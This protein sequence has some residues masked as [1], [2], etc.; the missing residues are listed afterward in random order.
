MTA[1]DIGLLNG[2]E[3]EFESCS[4]SLNAGIDG[5][6]C[7]FT[8]IAGLHL[9]PRKTDKIELALDGF[10]FR[11]IVDEVTTSY[12]G[13]SKK[14]S[15]SVIG[16][17]QNLDQ[18]VT[19]NQTGTAQELMETALDGKGFNAS[20]LGDTEEASFKLPYTGDVR[21]F[22]ETI[23]TAAGGFIAYLDSSGTCYLINRNGGHSLHPHKW[24]PGNRGYQLNNCK[25]PG[26][27]PKTQFRCTGKNAK[28]DG[29]GP[30]SEP[31][32]YKEAG[33]GT[34][35][36]FSYADTWTE[37]SRVDVDGTRVEFIEKGVSGWDTAACYHDPEAHK[38]VF[39]VAPGAGLE[40]KL[41]GIKH[42][43]D[44]TETDE[45][46]AAELAAAFGGTGIHPVNESHPEFRTQ[47]ESQKFAEG[48]KAR[49]GGIKMEATAT[50]W[51]P[52]PI[53][54]PIHEVEVDD[55]DGFAATLPVQSNSGTREAGR[56][57]QSVTVGNGR[58]GGSAPGGASA[59]NAVVS[60]IRRAT[61]PAQA[62]APTTTVPYSPV[63][64][65]LLD[66]PLCLA[67]DPDGNLFISDSSNYRIRRVDAGTGIITTYAGTGTPGHSGDGG[68]AS[69]AAVYGSFLLTDLKVE[70]GYL[71]LCG[72]EDGTSDPS[73]WHTAVRRINLS[74]G[75][76]ELFAGNYTAGD[77]GDGGAATSAKLDYPRGMAFVGGDLYL[78]T[79]SAF[80][81][82]PGNIRKISG[83]T[84]TRILDSDT[85]YNGITVNTDLVGFA[86]GSAGTLRAY[87]TD[88]TGPTDTAT[89]LTAA[90]WPVYDPDGDRYFAAG[91]NGTTYQIFTI[92]PATGD[93]TLF[94]GDGTQ[95]YSGDGGPAVDAQFRFPS[96]VPFGMTIFDGYLYLSDA[97]NHC[98]RRVNLGTGI[99]SL[100]AGTPETSGF[101]GDGGPAM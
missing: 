85:L 71:Y 49:Y 101:D 51:A 99:V 38:V 1:P 12:E 40:V 14:Y 55:G 2:I 53:Y 37:V 21:G 15:V 35:I 57:I 72:L 67:L 84:I 45:A 30:D 39:K 58:E 91:Y 90:I 25:Y 5:S 69:A 62:P 66:Y 100:V 92:D 98:V 95:G 16:P 24:I 65:P 61:T 78:P 31:T 68:P 3:T 88:G 28:P 11:G 9:K 83:G 96:N 80:F 43:S 8:F 74:T 73:L 81:D 22:L 4:F 47:Q 56:W 26:G 46:L 19:I 97:G 79:G 29:G 89:D 13:R 54:L 32:E 82:S 20:V 59:F 6:T 36:E 64:P 87:A 76:I 17:Q 23:Q 33:D 50:V 94:A 86:D 27:L 44:H 60:R 48:M 34:K 75:N 93:T 18:P 42:Y 77:D 63:G 41:T 70:S 52:V 10:N 7:N